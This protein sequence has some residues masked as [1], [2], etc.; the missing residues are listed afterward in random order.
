MF[1]RNDYD[2]IQFLKR[3]NA[4]KTKINDK[5]ESFLSINL[6]SNLDLSIK[7]EKVNEVRT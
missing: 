7:K 3:T 2:E 1:K 5:I 6:N 4:K